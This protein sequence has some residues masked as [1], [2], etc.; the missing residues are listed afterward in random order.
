MSAVRNRRNLS[1][2]GANAG[3][4]EWAEALLAATGRLTPEQVA[5]V[6]EKNPATPLTRTLRHYLIRLKRR[7]RRPGVKPK[8]AAAWEFILFDAKALYETRLREYL[9]RGKSTGTGR[10][11]IEDRAAAASEHAYKAVLAEMKANICDMDWMALR[12]LISLHIRDPRLFLDFEAAGADDT[13]PEAGSDGPTL[14]EFIND[15]GGCGM[16]LGGFAA[17]CPISVT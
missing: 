3:T 6:L 17:T 8:N 7:D 11:A 13:D 2:Y 14:P 12:N 9:D 10:D 16:S 15:N 1:S 5:Q 4:F